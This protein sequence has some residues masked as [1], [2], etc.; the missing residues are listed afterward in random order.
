[1]G[2]HIENVVIIGI[3]IAMYMNLYLA[4]RLGR[5]TEGAVTFERHF[6]AAFDPMGSNA[7]LSF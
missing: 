4:T 1:M 5:L 2:I 6:I 7:R 3:T